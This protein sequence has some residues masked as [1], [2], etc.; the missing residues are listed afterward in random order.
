MCKMMEDIKVSSPKEERGKEYPAGKKGNH[1]VPDVVR[2]TLG[3]GQA[4]AAGKLVDG[5]L[6]VWGW[7]E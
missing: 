6:R 2:K 3:C 5:R 1:D 7:L 4:R